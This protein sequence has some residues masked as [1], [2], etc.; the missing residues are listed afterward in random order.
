MKKLI[1]LVAAVAGLGSL[2]AQSIGKGAIQLGGTVGFSSMTDKPVGGIT[3]DSTSLSIAPSASYFI[4]DDISVGLGIG[5]ISSTIKN[6]FGGSTS[7]VN[8]T[9][10]GFSPKVSYYKMVNDQ[11]GLFGSLGVDYIMASGEAKNVPSSKMSE[12]FFGA[13]ITPGIIFFPAPKWAIHAQLTNG[14]GYS[15]RTKKDNNDK[16]TGTVSNFGVNLGLSQIQF[17]VSY[18]IGRGE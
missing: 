13:G 15:S 10:F 16:E 18:F 1:L 14:L 2:N 12:T 9:G 3:K 6:T 4:T 5:F 7:E 11:F 17:G 8:A